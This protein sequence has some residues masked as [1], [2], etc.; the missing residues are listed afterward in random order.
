MGNWYQN[1]GLVQTY[2]P[3]PLFRGVRLR[4]TTDQTSVNTTPGAAVSWQADGVDFD[5][6]RIWNSDTPTRLIIPQGVTLVSIV[7]QV[8]F[9]ALTAATNIT[10]TVAKNGSVAW[11]GRPRCALLMNTGSCTMQVSSGAFQ[12]NQ[13]DYLELWVIHADTDVTF[14]ADTTVL[15]LSILQ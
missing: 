12:V 13:D 6:D 5:T 14:S 2:P 7:G 15:A 1:P 4:R 10:L 8:G 3:R 9:Q 11:S